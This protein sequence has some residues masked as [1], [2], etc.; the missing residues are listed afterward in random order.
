MKAPDSEHLFNELTALNNELVNA[1]R[2]LVRTNERLTR[3]MEELSV[4]QEW[5]TASINMLPDA[6][7]TADPDRRVGYVNESAVSL[8][9]LPRE[10]LIG[11]D[12][13]ELVRLQ[14]R[15]GSPLDPDCLFGEGPQTKVELREATGLRLRS[16]DGSNRPVAGNVTS[17]HDPHGERIGLI[18]LLRDTTEVVQF[19]YDSLGQSRREAAETIAA[20]LLHDL[21]NLLMVVLAN[22]EAARTQLSSKD[23][24][25]IRSLSNIEH[26]GK[27]ADEFVRNVLTATISSLDRRAGLD[28]EE[29]LRRSSEIF[30]DLHPT[31]AVKIDMPEAPPP[32]SGNGDAL[33]MGLR[34]LLDNAAESMNGS[35]TIT[36]AVRVVR[37]EADGRR[38]ST[39]SVQIEVRDTGAGMTPEVRERALDPFYSTKALGRGLGL[40]VAQ[41]I[42]KGHGGSLRIHSTVGSG[43]SVMIDLPIG[44]APGY[45]LSSEVSADSASG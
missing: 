7:L 25:V 35:G 22:A 26:A 3:S 31:V 13:K 29:V 42:A 32:I 45:G 33:A 12:L 15:S 36:I 41:G 21:N 18:L 27:R 20:A 2:E 39:A 37:P 38:G 40:S 19:Y 5:I 10:E 43:T 23:V 30:A 9:G 24:K 17:I 16:W 8:I 6:V 28:L 4:R 11:K 44:P 1:R 14:D 34:N